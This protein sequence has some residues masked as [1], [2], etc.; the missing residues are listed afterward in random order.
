MKT[1]KILKHILLLSLLFQL[2]FAQAQD[3]SASA[4]IDRKSITIG[5]QTYYTLSCAYPKNATVEW[6]E[7]QDTLVNGI[8]ILGMPTI[9][10]VEESNANIHLSKKYLIT[11]FDSALYHIPALNF[12]LY[13]DRDTTVHEFYS[14]SLFLQVLSVEVDTSAAINDIHPPY[15]E[16]LRLK[17]IMPWIIA[18]VLLLAIIVF[19]IYYLKKRKNNE[20]IFTIK[21]KY[22]PPHEKALAAL[23]K[24][25]ENQR[26]KK[27]EI[28]EY[29]TELTDVIREYISER[30]Q[31]D[32]M[33][34][35][36]GEIIAAIENEIENIQRQKLQQLLLL[37]DMVKFA[38]LK[39]LPDEHSKS[40]Q[41][42]FDFVLETKIEEDNKTEDNGKNVA[43]ADNKEVLDN[44]KKE[45]NSNDA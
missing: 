31:F 10:T 13:Y 9:D 45:G 17:E 44:K 6:P 4:K 7:L 36:S 21:E 30:F 40:L 28:K 41:L 23:T 2:L 14:D 5:D 11:S 33:E 24:I 25:K 38:K 8:E 43:E 37:A 26:W 42:A 29:Y 20:G 16:P 3:Y 39:P 12:K 27:D 15:K 19:L 22:I 18:G 32:A 1:M 34:M 35:I